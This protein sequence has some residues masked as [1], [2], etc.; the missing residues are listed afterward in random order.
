M[1][2]GFVGLGKMGMGLVRNMLRRGHEVR[3]WNR[4]AGPAEA[5]AGDGAIAVP[6]LEALVSGLVPPRTVWLMVSHAAVEELF[7]AVLPLLQAGDTIIDDGNSPYLESE[8]RAAVCSGRGVNFID[9]GVSGGPGGARNGA[10][11]MVGGAR[12]AIVRYEALFAELAVPGGYLHV[13]TAGAGHFVKM[14]HNGIEYGMMQAIGEGFEV[15]RKSKFQLDLHAVAD[16]YNRGSVIESRLVGWLA[17]AFAEHGTE[18][19]AVSG[20]IAHSGEGQW[21]VD[22]AKRLAVPVPIIEGAL[23][24]RVDSAEHPSYTGRVVSA[25]RGQFGGHDVGSRK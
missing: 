24:F 4:S 3:V 10:C 5:A 6:T 22:E 23:Q 17:A 12:E 9:V 11:L 20:S 15:L 25:L 13:G 14:V 2:I 18:L 7:S 8:R 21:T 16:L 19:S 1:Q